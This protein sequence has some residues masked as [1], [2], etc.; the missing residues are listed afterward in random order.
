MERK[1]GASLEFDALSIEGALESAG[2]GGDD[3]SVRAA[4]SMGQAIYAGWLEHH[5]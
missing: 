5:M 3:D 1:I 4:M 2:A